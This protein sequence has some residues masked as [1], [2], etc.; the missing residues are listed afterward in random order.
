MQTERVLFIIGA[1]RARR[2]WPADL[3]LIRVL[4]NQCSDFFLLQ[5]GTLASEA[6]ARGILYEVPAERKLDDKLPIGIFGPDNTLVGLLEV[7]RDYRM[8]SEW[9]ISLMLLAPPSRKSG[10]GTQIH[11][12]FE[13]YASDQGV[14]RLLLAVLEGNTAAHRFWSKLGYRAVKTHLPR[15]YGRRIHACTEYEKVLS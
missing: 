4:N 14:E 6:E 8:R 3:P 13:S 2:L 11:D 7:L 5:N 10:L 15:L 12:A 9:W 1:H